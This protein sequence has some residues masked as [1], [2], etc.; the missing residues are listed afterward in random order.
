M[1]RRESRRCEGNWS[2]T[3]D[4]VS[5]RHLAS[6]TEKAFD[7]CDLMSPSSSTTWHPE[8]LIGDGTPK[9]IGVSATDLNDPYN[10][11]PLYN[12]P[13]HVSRVTPVSL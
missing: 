10:P 3:A 12:N 13:I 2:D 8:V 1:E 9:S 7:T 6:V 5:K 11:S 4:N